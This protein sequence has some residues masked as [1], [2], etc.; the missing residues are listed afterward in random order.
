[1]VCACGLYVYAS[2]GSGVANLHDDTLN[3]EFCKDSHVCWQKAHDAR[4]VRT[5]FHIHA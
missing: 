5:G 3:S 2:F 4:H 1:M